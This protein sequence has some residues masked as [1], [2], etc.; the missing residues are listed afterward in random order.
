ME[1]PKTQRAACPVP[2]CLH[3]EEF[4]L[5]QLGTYTVLESWNYLDW[6]RLLRSLS[7]TVNVILPGP[8]KD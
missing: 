1:M 8:P 3:G 6:K 7:P 4:S 5:C 2:D